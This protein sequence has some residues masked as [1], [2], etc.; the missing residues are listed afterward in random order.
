MGIKNYLIEGVSGTGKTSVASGLQS[1]GHHVVHGD[2]ELAYQG[3]PRTGKP[4]DVADHAHDIAFGHRHHIWDV[5]RV[6]ALVAD[7]SRPITFFCGGSRN[8]DRFIDL[9]DAVFVLDVDAETLLK[10]LASRPDDEFGASQAERDLV[11]HLHAT[12][13]DIPRNATFI[14]ATAPLDAVI[15]DILARCAA[16]D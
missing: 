12:G 2:R 13:E 15:D 5:D 7:H 11:L 4:L 9:V 10:R 1:R 8:F 6:R 16:S 14:D 3:D